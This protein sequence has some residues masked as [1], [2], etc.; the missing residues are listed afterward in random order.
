MKAFKGNRTRIF[1]SV[2]AI[3]G[4]TETYAR[5]VIPSEYQGLFLFVV[6]AAIIILRQ[7][8]TTP[9]GEKL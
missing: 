1:G 7:I 4:L 2:I 6:G 5:E 3:L 8:T 9:P